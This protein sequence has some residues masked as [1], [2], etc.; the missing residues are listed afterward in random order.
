MLTKDSCFENIVFPVNKPDNL[1]FDKKLKLINQ[2]NPN[3]SV[4][5]EDGIVN[6]VPTQSVPELFKVKIRNVKLVFDNN[7]NLV[8]GT[9]L[10]KPEVTEKLKEL[11]L[12]E[13][14]QFG[15]L[16]SPPNHLP[17]TEMVFN[18]KTLQQILNEIVKKK[19]GRGVWA[20]RE[21]H[22]NGEDIFTLDFPVK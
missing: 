5:N 10:Q 4:K 12:G 18:D 11:N 13:C 20:Y 19:R 22:Y 6:L 21:F 17:P 8:I 16:Q 2:L 1:S 9:L 3:Y 7:L 15:G 14:M